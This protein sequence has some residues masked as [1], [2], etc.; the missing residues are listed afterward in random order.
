[1]FGK[2]RWKRLL[3]ISV[4][5]LGGAGI[6]GYFT[7]PYVSLIGAPTAELSAGA[8]VNGGFRGSDGKSHQFSDYRGKVLVLEWTSPICEFTIRHYASGAMHA[9]QEYGAAKQ[10]AWIPVN[11]AAPN[12]ISYLDAA[13]AQALLASRK[14]GSPF[15]AMD[16]TG[17]L[18][19]M[20]GA[21]AT[22]SVAIIDAQGKLAYIGAIDNQPWGD[23]TTGTNYVRQALDE[24]SAGKPVTV[25]FTRSYGCGIKYP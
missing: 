3:V 10:A 22:P 11:T 20:F 1:M 21:H 4:L 7:L 13:G 14:I 18:G 17:E 23:G 2:S 5:L 9:L 8:E 16:E 6:L 19:R 24:L 25:S 15:I 12:G